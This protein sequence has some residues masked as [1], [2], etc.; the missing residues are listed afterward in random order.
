MRSAPRPQGRGLIRPHPTAAEC[1]TAP[2]GRCWRCCEYPGLKPTGLILP[3][4]DISDVCRQKTR[5]KT[6]PSEKG[7][8]DDQMSAMTAHR[9]CYIFPM[10]L[11]LLCP[12][13]PWKRRASR[14]GAHAD[15]GLSTC[16]N[17]PRLNREQA[18][19]FLVSIRCS[20]SRLWERLSVN[21]I[22]STGPSV[23]RG[24]DLHSVR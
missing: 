17:G 22:A 13:R 15:V 18:R 21:R 8:R 24:P 2:F 23:H 12:F 10:S 4:F 11:C 6:R 1:L 9:R 16:S 3:A 7:R 14:V 19:S 20:T 5:V